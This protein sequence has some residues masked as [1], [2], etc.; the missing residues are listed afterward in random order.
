MVFIGIG[1]FAFSIVFIGILSTQHHLSGDDIFA[2]LVISFVAS[3]L[4]PLTIMVL[5]LVFIALVLYEVGKWIGE[6]I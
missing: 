1:L 6:K 4:W 2:F 3:M 5:I